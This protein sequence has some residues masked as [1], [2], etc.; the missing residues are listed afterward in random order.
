[1]R[2]FAI[3]SC[4]CLATPAF[5]F[6]EP[7]AIDGPLAVHLAQPDATPGINADEA[8]ALL[9]VIYADFQANP[10]G[11]L[12]ATEKALL[13]QL[14]AAKAQVT[15]TLNG[16]KTKLGPLLPDG[17]R[18]LTFADKGSNDPLKLWQEGDAESVRDMVRLYGIRVPAMR[19][20]VQQVVIA[21]LKLGWNNSTIGNNYGPLADKIRRTV[22]LLETASPQ[23]R[24]TGRMLLFDSMR[25]LDRSTNDSIPDYLYQFLK[26]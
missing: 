1:M 3:L 4:F 14:L 21:D 25:S 17:V 13:D 15:V 10:G 19:N 11:A 6:T 5:A 9:N 8:A 16:K 24:K 12:S 18:F 23:T 20:V 26:N 7:L 22:N 2:C